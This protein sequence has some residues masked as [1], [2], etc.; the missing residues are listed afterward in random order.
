MGHFSFSQRHIPTKKIILSAPPRS[1]S[2][3][4]ILYSLSYIALEQLQKTSQSRYIRKVCAGALWEIYDGK[5]AVSDDE[6]ASV[7]KS[8]L[9]LKTDTEK[10]KKK[11]KDGPHVM[12]SYQW[13]VQKRMI[14]LK[15]LLIKHGYNVWMDIERMGTGFLCT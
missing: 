14:I 11:K 9:N 2:L 6:T 5:I 7:N 12:I 15:D 1:S 10:K 3:C 8:Q 13:D 4:V